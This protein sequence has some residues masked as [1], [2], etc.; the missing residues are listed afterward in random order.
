MR[1]VLE[2]RP[3]RLHPMVNN[4]NCNATTRKQ[5]TMALEQFFVR[6]LKDRRVDSKDVTIV[7]DGF[8]TTSHN[9]NDENNNNNPWPTVVTNGDDVSH[10]NLPMASSSVTTSSRDDNNNNNDNDNSCNTS[11]TSR[12]S[13]GCL[14]SPGTPGLTKTIPEKFLSDG[15]VESIGVRYP[16]WQTKTKDA[17]TRQAPGDV[18]IGYNRR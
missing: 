8:L 1:I 3:S 4:R 9:D 15:S 11:A 17:D 13:V 7:P 18:A 14:S 2:Q 6:L 10:R 5:G 12:Q 16:P